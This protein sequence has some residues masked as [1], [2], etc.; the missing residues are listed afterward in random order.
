MDAAAIQQ[1][2]HDIDWDQMFGFSNFAFKNI[3]RKA[4]ARAY[5]SHLEF[6]LKKGI[7]LPTSLNNGHQVDLLIT[8]I[9]AA[10]YA[11]PT[12]DT[13][14]TPFKAVAVDLRTRATRDPRKRIAG[15]I[16]AGD[17]VAAGRL[18]AGAAGRP[19]P[20]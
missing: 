12:F 1:M 8:R 18:S 15:P 5:P 6:G 9:T 4:D 10:Y 17:D 11:D 20:G 16:A 7:V 14:P 13:L 19:R 3:R 2:L